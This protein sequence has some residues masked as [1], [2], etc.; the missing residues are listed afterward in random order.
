[1]PLPRDIAG[2]LVLALGLAV[3]VS[4]ALAPREGR[5]VGERAGLGAGLDAGASGQSV[6]AL[7]EEVRTLRAEVARLGRG[8][9]LPEFPLP[10]SMSFAGSR[11][12][13]ERPEVRQRLDYELLI[14]LGRPAMPLLWI[15]R[16]DRV[17]PELSEAL[18]EA[19]LPADLLYV[20]VI[21]S[22]LRSEVSSPAGAVGLWQFM[23]ATGRRYGLRIDRYVDERRHP[24]RATEAA[25]RY[26]RELHEEFGDW[27]LAMAAYNSGERRVREA[28]AKQD[29]RDYFSLYL[30]GETRRYVYRALA[31]KL[32]LEDPEA[33]GLSLP[34]ERRLPAPR[35]REETVRVSQSREELAAVARSFG[36][37]YL[38]FREL[39]PQLR[40]SYLPRGS[41]RITLPAEE[42]GAGGPVAAA[43]ALGAAA[44][45]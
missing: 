36:V 3:S 28:V 22:D 30:P 38:T 2:L 45:R 1:V 18:D 43:G 37:P 39:N 12:P 31:A 44:S 13:L 23:R 14:A 8:T 41:Y 42:A 26:L 24:W 32:I 20:A 27:F 9:R 35:T 17:L 33:Y 10:R 25:L 11:V 15:K 16:S 5:A 34:P 40:G 6:E 7:L 21:E 29:E 19:G 4:L